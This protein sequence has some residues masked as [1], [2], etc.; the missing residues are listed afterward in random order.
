MP[1]TTLAQAL[2]MRGKPSTLVATLR[3]TL[4]HALGENASAYPGLAQG[5]EFDALTENA[6]R[7]WQAGAGLIAD[8]IAGPRTLAALGLLQLPPLAVALE[9]AQVKRLFPYTRSSSIEQHLPYVAA[10]LAA[11]NLCNQDL[12]IAALGTIRAETEGFVP[13]SEQP[14]HFNTRPGQSAFSAYENLDTLGNCEPGDGARFRGRGY[15]QLTGR[16]NYELFGLTLGFALHEQP[17]SACAPEIAACLLAAFLSK[18]RERLAQAMAADDLRGARKIINGGSHGLDRFKD[19]VQRALALWKTPT[20]T[21]VTAIKPQLA[22]SRRASLDV[23]K[24]AA[25]LRD[26]AYQPPPH[27]LLK[28][29]PADDQI[30]R[31]IGAYTQAG[32]ILDQGREGACTGFGLACVANYLRW[33]R[34]LMANELELNENGLES[35]SPR[36]L[37][38]FA[39]RYDEYEGENYEGSSCRG[40]L[41]GWYINGVCLESDWR[42]QPGG[43]SQ[44]SPGWNLRAREHTLGVYYR[45][46]PQAITDLQ[47]AIQEIGAIYVSAYTH[48]GWEHVPTHQTAPGSHANLPEISYAGKPSRTG[49]HAFALVGYNR[50]GFVLQNSWGPDWGAGGFA[51]ISYADWL[52]H[53]MDA[54]VAA[55]GVPGVVAGQLASEQTA[56]SQAQAAARQLHWWD[57]ETAYRHSLVLGNNGRV[58]RYDTVDGVT[59]TLQH[60]ACVLPDAW[61]RQNAQ[62]V[63]RLVLYAHG[64]LNSEA[65]AIERAQAM[66]RYFLG[67]GCYP[68]FLVWKSG[69]LESISNLLKDRSEKTTPAGLAG[70]W[71]SDGFSDPVLEKTVGRPLVR[72]IWSEMKENAE[73]ASENGHGGDLLAEAL[74]QLAASWGQDF[75]LHLIGHSAGSIILGRLLAKLT[76][77]GLGERIGSV[78]LYAPAC[79]V[80]FANRYYAP[81]AEIMQR[82]HLHLL[83]ERRER[84]DNVGQIYRKSLLYFVSNALEA[85]PRLPIL[86]L[87]NV[88]KPDY[89]GWDGSANTAEVLLNWRT[90]AELSRLKSRLHVH[91]EETITTRIG[92]GNAL[93][94]R[95]E[96]T[97]HGGF[98]N[99]VQVIAR[100]I[101]TITG[102]KQLALPVD[103]LI[104][105]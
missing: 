91:D 69:L 39:R 63:K 45:I 60:Q 50:T 30:H 67:N 62:P 5:S 11:F 9:P 76:Q 78:H 56:S 66:G 18:H 23:I 105:F 22:V 58:Q 85:D 40:A 37:Y 77:K 41:K 89:Q 34:A 42:Y 32:L 49:G 7:A 55:L 92:Q 28:Q 48:E 10:A 24:D 79:S 98:D 80:S 101:E 54:W 31:F 100:T 72:P 38:Q 14:S 29:Y 57:Q 65:A 81:H 70:N 33:R 61:F 21:L 94:P 52:A 99:N 96:K 2:L 86:G 53:A 68:L 95:T 36:M 20:A 74:R 90:S 71:F 43:A 3:Q 47:A 93:A 35:V 104:G 84:D 8:G 46:A 15:V 82:L 73:L 12:V 51:V 59:R 19:T 97:S 27:S 87:E 102:L 83:S 4:A 75:E 17:D 26:R 6:L 88:F 16:K 1:E 25:D 44:P 13:I 103:D 64:G